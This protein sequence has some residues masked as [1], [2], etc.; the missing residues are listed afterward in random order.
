MRE[1]P[2]IYLDRRVEVLDRITTAA[3]MMQGTDSLDQ[4]V[5]YEGVNV[6]EACDRGVIVLDGKERTSRKL[7]PWH[8]VVSFEAHTRDEIWVV[9]KYPEAARRSL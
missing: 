9:V 1:E 7:Y 4:K 8:R 6:Y 3:G 2:S 5:T